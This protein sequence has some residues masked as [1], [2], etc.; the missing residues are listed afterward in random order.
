M[1]SDAVLLSCLV[2]VQ[3]SFLEWHANSEAFRS[4]G[5]L[6]NLTSLSLHAFHCSSTALSDALWQLLNLRTLCLSG[7]IVVTPMTQL[8]VLRKL[9]HLDLTQDV[10]VSVMQG[11]KNPH[12]VTNS[13]WTHSV[14]CM[15]M[16]FGLHHATLFP[17][18]VQSSMWSGSVGLNVCW[19]VYLHMLNMIRTVRVVP[20]FAGL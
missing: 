9:E 13:A 5:A 15:L 18:L 1:N 20:M 12:V 16:M 14:L 19:T 11:C 7:R 2:C 10:Q 17:H 6:S 3:G 4:L 8:S